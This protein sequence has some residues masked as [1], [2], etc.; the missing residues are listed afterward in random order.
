MAPAPNSEMA[1]RYVSGS[2]RQK[3]PTCALN[4]IPRIKALFSLG[5]GSRVSPRFSPAAR[6]SRKGGG[7]GRGS[8]RDG[9]ALTVKT[10]TLSWS[11]RATCSSSKERESTVS[12]YSRFSAAGPLSPK[13]SKLFV[14]QP[15]GRD[16]AR[17]AV[18]AR[19]RPPEQKPM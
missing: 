10:L 5:G 3:S 1:Q 17:R 19:I 2:S 12:L 7:D 8:V 16:I 6:R 11:I 18:R 15:S 14:P 9:V 13:P 4:A